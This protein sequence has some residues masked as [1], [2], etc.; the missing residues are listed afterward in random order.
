[1]ATMKWTCWIPSFFSFAVQPTVN[2]FRSHSLLSS[3]WCKLLIKWIF[4]VNQTCA[5]KI[6]PN[7]TRPKFGSKFVLVK[8]RTKSNSE[9][10]VSFSH[11]SFGR[12]QSCCKRASSSTCVEVNDPTVA[13]NEYDDS[14]C[15]TEGSEEYDENQGESTT[16]SIPSASK[17]KKIC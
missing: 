11:Q 7:S 13:H 8:L 10:F 16:A 6:K 12:F 9:L 5:I 3:F 1:M 4:L 14:L 15:E 2:L 17:S